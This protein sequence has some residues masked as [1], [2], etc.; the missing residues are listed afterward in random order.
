MIDG[1]LLVD[2][3]EGITSYDV[4]RR[5]KKEYPK[6]TKIGHTGTLDPF[7]SG[8]LVILIGRAATKLM[9]RFHNLKKEYIVE[10][11]FGFETDT[12]D[13]TG[14]KIFENMKKSRPSLGKIK[15]IIEKDFLGLI[16]QIPPK[17]SA[18]KVKGRKAYELARENIDFK[19][20]PKNIEIY[21]F[22]IL[23][24]K[25]P[26]IRFRVVCST[27]TYIRTLVKDL[28]RELNTYATATNLRRV[29]IGTFTVENVNSSI[30]GVDKVLK[31]LDE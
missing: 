30:I 20:K 6:G 3:E 26:D 10:A 16:S 2:K 14:E 15:R 28:A 13:I 23:E 7:A 24:Y 27:G 22:E 31:I 25:Y 19:L 1:I 18:K 12:Q 5:I 8:L 29:R 9:D 11:K 17:Y 4:I 21:E